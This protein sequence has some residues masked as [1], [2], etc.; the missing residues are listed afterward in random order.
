MRPGLSRVHVHSRPNVLE[1][2]STPRGG[3]INRQETQGFNS[4]F[5][6]PRL[7]T[8]ARKQFYEDCVP[9]RC[10]ED[11]IKRSVLRS[12]KCLEKVRLL[13]HLSGHPRSPERSRRVSYPSGAAKRADPSYSFSSTTAQAHEP[14]S[15]RPALLAPRILQGTLDI[16]ASS[17]ST[18][19]QDL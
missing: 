12:E 13:L 4:K 9:G 15:S 6:K 1:H 17:W 16:K 3:K 10:S 19:R 7:H 2:L 18:Y 5:C 11:I 8:S 14:T